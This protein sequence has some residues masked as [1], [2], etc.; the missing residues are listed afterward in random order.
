MNRKGQV[1]M[2]IT[3]IISALV[4]VLIAAVFAPMGVLFNT[5]MYLAG[6]DILERS[7]ESIQSITNIEVKQN[8]QDAINNGFTAAEDNIEV[9]ANLFQ[10]G[11]ILVVGVTALVIFIFTRRLIEFGAGGFI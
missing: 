6:Q 10:Y 5:E 8:V 7:N 3:F 9:N 1:M 4:I 11:W 2:F